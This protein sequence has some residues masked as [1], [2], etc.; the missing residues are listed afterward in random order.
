[1]IITSVDVA[2]CQGDYRCNDRRLMLSCS[3]TAKI[4]IE[5]YTCTARA[6]DKEKSWMIRPEVAESKEIKPCQDPKC[7]AICLRT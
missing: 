4:V 2:P 7:G 3:A 5:I 1:M 6:M